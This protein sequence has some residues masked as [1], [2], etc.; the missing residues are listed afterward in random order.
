MFSFQPD[1]VS[2]LARLSYESMIEQGYSV[3]IYS[4][5]APREIGALPIPAEHIDARQVV[6]EELVFR[7]SNGG[8]EG[9]TNLF[10]FAALH[11]HGGLWIDN[12][13]VLLRRLAG[14]GALA[15]QGESIRTPLPYI[16][17]VPA[18]SAFAARG[19]ELA[20][21]YRNEPNPREL[22]CSKLGKEWAELRA[23]KLPPAKYCPIHPSELQQVLQVSDFKLSRVSGLHLW[24]R[25]WR[26]QEIGFG[27]GF[28]TDS[29][30]EILWRELFCSGD[31]YDDDDVDGPLSDDP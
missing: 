18:R 23:R 13:Y 5:E 12:D 15:I 27:A 29:T 4:Y 30:Y 24:Q 11:K 21:K 10:Q 16:L 22:T 25:E 28:P 26:R 8:W 9:F 7:D 2:R 3:S 17:R 19:I 31:D 20:G 1:N 6:P 14:V